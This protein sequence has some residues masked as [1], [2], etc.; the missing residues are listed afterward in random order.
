MSTFDERIEAFL[1]LIWNFL[2]YIMETVASFIL[3]PIRVITHNIEAIGE[4]NHVLLPITAL[5]VLLL[6]YFMIRLYVEFDEA[7]DVV[8]S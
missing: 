2:T 5:G 3:N 4:V 8:T 7:L 1:T 6:A